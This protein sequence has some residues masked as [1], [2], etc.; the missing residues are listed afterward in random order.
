MLC[1]SL[2]GKRV[3]D[4]MNTCTVQLLFSALETITTLQI[5]YTPILN[6]KFKKYINK[7][8]KHSGSSIDCKTIYLSITQLSTS[9]FLGLHSF[10]LILFSHFGHN[11]QHPASWFGCRMVIMQPLMLCPSPPLR[12]TLQWTNLCV[13]M[14]SHSTV[15]DSFVRHHGL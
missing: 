4:R 12:V 8:K 1:G 11:H 9:K 14:L 7:E 10:G 6:K 5:D 13:C 3:G 2:E 15:S